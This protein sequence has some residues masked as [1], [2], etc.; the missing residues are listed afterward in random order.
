MDSSKQ[1]RQP[2]E[3]N[4]TDLGQTTYIRILHFGKDMK[5]DMNDM[6]KVNRE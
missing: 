6:E 1:Q 2:K 3:E 5:K 4:D